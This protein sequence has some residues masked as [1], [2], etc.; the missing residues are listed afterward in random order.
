[1]GLWNRRSF[2]AL[3]E[4]EG[5]AWL[6]FETEPLSELGWYQSVMEREYLPGGWKRRLYYGLGGGKALARALRENAHSIAGHTLVGFFA[7][8]PAQPSTQPQPSR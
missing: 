5:L 4:L 8:S 7:V 1:M 3:A 6:R 2:V